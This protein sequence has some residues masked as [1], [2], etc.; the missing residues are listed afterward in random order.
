MKIKLPGRKG[1]YPY[2]YISSFDYFQ[3]TESTKSHKVAF[4]ND[5]DEANIS[6]NLY[7]V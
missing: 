1:E 7:T 6:A 3:E 4:D 2:R 5:L